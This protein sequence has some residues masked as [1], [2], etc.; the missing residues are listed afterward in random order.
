MT[1]S[2]NENSTSETTIK[3]QSS[4]IQLLQK[5]GFLQKLSNFYEEF[6]NFCKSFS[7]FLK[8]STF[9]ESSNF[10]FEFDIFHDNF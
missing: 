8:K 2:G 1:S 7:T 6:T 9:C 3:K 10:L 4:T 5:N